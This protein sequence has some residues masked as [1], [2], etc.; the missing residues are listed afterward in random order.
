MIPSYRTLLEMA[1]STTLDRRSSPAQSGL[2]LSSAVPVLPEAPPITERRATRR[3][4]RRDAATSAP[5][6]ALVD[7]AKDITAVIVTGREDVLGRPR[8]SRNARCTHAISPRQVETEIGSRPITHEKSRRFS[9]KPD[10]AS[11]AREGAEA[12]NEEG[13]SG[14]PVARGRVASAARDSAVPGFRMA[15]R[16]TRLRSRSSSARWALWTIRRRGRRR[17]SILDGVHTAEDDV[18]V[19]RG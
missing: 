17:Q 6:V 11:Q 13:I 15:T 16:T 9:Q 5:S 19:E 4:L 1:A 3:P 2:T 7:V 12:N 18:S 14:E 8:A 10:R